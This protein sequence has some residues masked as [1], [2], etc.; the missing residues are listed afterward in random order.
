MKQ[1][2]VTK[3]ELKEGTIFFIAAI[4]I[5]VILGLLDSMGML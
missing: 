4:V 2:K 5:V 1:V 3:N